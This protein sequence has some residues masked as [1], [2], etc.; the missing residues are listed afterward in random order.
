[1]RR[2]SL[3]TIVSLA[4]IASAV[5]VVISL[6][7][8]ANDFRRSQTLTSTD[9]ETLLYDRMLEMDRLLIESSEL[10]G[11]LVQA[12]EDAGGLS[13]VDRGRFLAYEHILYDSWELA[14]VSHA[15]GVLET[16]AFEDW[17]AWF[18]RSA[19]RRPAFGWKG[20]RANHMDDFIQYVESQLKGD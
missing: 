9:V 16:S 17:N 6:L 5:A 8:L 10:A 14:W 12:A 7:Y 2:V 20:N 15:D 19:R 4:E 3:Q 18:A 1:M 11:I 13:P